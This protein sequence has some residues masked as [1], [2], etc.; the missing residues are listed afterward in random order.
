[1]DERRIIGL[2][3]DVASEHTARVLGGDGK[4]VAKGKAIPT[5]ESLGALE[6]AAL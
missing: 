2:D 4:V 3:L 6:R 1:M 5:T